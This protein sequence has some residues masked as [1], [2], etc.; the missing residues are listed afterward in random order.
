VH[1]GGSS[2]T[3]TDARPAADDLLSRWKLVEWPDDLLDL[4]DLE[5][6]RPILTQIERDSL[7]ELRRSA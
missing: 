2:F 7:Q 3:G 5:R 4:L 6:N 1:G